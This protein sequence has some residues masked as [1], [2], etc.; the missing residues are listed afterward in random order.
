MNIYVIFSILIL[1]DGIKSLAVNS[2][3]T[4]ITA[5]Y[6]ATVELSCELLD[7][8][9]NELNWRKINGVIFVLVISAIFFYFYNYL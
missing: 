4:L 6:N 8:Y 9:G 3:S 5:K 7:K 2:Q 1:I